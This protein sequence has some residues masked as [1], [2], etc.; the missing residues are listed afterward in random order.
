MILPSDIR[1]HQV[2]VGGQSLYSLY[3]AAIHMSVQYG[4]HVRSKLHIRVN[5]E[6][7]N[8]GISRGQNL[9]AERLWAIMSS[10]MCAYEQLLSW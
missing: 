10:G 3:P 4:S 2:M 7:L 1:F 5:E 9:S 8:A 6:Q